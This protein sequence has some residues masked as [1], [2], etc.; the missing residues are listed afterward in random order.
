MIDLGL[1]VLSP[2][3]LTYEFSTIGIL[4]NID[5]F[6][7]TSPSEKPPSEPVG[8]CLQ[9]TGDIVVVYDN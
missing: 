9:S 3:R 2:T 1:E 5:F 7:P 6:I 8:E 4:R